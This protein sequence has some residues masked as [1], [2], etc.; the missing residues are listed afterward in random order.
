MAVRLA[1]SIAIEVDADVLL[2]DEVL[3]VG[4]AAFQHKCFQQFERLKAE[5]KTIVFVTHDMSSVE[6]FCDRALLIEKGE[7]VILGSPRDVAR[8]YNQMNFSGVVHQQVE[9]GRHGDRK[10]AEITRVWFEN[11][12]WDEVTSLAQGTFCHGMFEVRFHEDMEDPIVGWTLQH[13]TGQTVMAASSMFE[14]P[15]TG[16]F[17]AGETAVVRITFQMRFAAG[18]YSLSPFITQAANMADVVDER[19]HAATVLV[20]STRSTGGMVDLDQLLE[21]RRT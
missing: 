6:R 14:H 11:D 10:S 5:G 9:P 13:L 8:A 20:H 3:A 21:I 19:E 2:V 15:H 1:F 4:D 12:A 17:E 18:Q 16:R 7:M